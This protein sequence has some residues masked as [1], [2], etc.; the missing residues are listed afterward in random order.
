VEGVTNK[1]RLQ[2]VVAEMT[3]EEAATALALAILSEAEKVV[4]PRLADDAEFVRVTA[5]TWCSCTATRACTAS[6]AASTVHATAP[7]GSTW[8]VVHVVGQRQH[9]DD[10][11]RARELLEALGAREAAVAVAPGVTA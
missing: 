11:R 5:G 1:E 8:R 10:R 3:Q 2:Q 6:S 4:L 9:S 7:A